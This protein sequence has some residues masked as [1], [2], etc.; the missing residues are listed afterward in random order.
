MRRFL[1]S[2]LFFSYPLRTYRDLHPFPNAR[3]SDLSTCSPVPLLVAETSVQ[4]C[5]PSVKRI[6]VS[7]EPAPPAKTVLPVVSAGSTDRKSTSELQSL[8]YLVCRLLLEKK[9][10][11]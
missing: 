3:S 8:A 10:K 5:P 2:S 6:S 7:T 9:K 4:V 1:L 11:K